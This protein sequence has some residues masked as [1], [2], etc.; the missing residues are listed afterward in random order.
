MKQQRSD[1]IFQSVG[2]FQCFFPVIDND[3]LKEDCNLNMRNEKFSHIP[4][5]CGCNSSEGA[6]V[7][8]MLSKFDLPTVSKCDE[9]FK[10]A[11]S[12]LMGVS[13]LD[14]AGFF[15]AVEKEYF[16]GVDDEDLA[17]Q[18]VEMWGDHCFVH[19]TT[20]TAKAH[21]GETSM[22]YSTSSLTVMPFN[23]MPYIILMPSY[24]HKSAFMSEYILEKVL[25]VELNEPQKLKAV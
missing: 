16:E 6:M 24:S 17:K 15:K 1:V 10:T 19:P 7:T 9:L 3:V 8:Y 18:F 20:V 13:K 4:F 22:P 5:I 11:L 2:T 25:R 23:T 12:F 21:C 14:Y